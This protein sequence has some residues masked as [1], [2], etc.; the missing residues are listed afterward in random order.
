MPFFRTAADIVRH[1]ESLGLFHVDMGLA[2]MRR[3][4]AALTLSHFPGVVVQ[5]LGTNGKGSTAAFL[6]SLALAHGCRTG[7]YTSPHFVSPAERVRLGLP[8]CGVFAPWPIHRW[9][10]AA[11]DVMDVAPDLTYFEFLTVLA[12]LV[13][14]REGVELVVMEAGLGGRHD[15][16]TAV[17]ADC[18][19]FSPIAMDHRDVLGPTLQDIA[20]DKA[21]A[22]R[23]S[24]PVCMAPQFPLAAAAL[25]EAVRKWKAELVTATPVAADV[26]LGLFGPHQRI[27]AGLALAA[28]DRLA[29]LLGKNRGDSSAESRGLARAFLPGRLQRVPGSSQ[30]PPMLLDGAHNPHGMSAL[31][32]A[33]QAADIHPAG[34]VYA[35]LRD[36][37]WQPA[38]RLLRRHV[39]QVPFFVV[40]LHNPRAARP[41]DIAAVL[42]SPPLA[43]TVEMLHGDGCLSPALVRA[44]A[45]PRAGE[46]NPLL[47]TG[48][49]YLLSEFFALYPRHLSPEGQAQGEVT[50]FPGGKE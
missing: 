43:T 34:V 44:R 12:L 46:E 28:W 21:G 4:L 7:L 15:A 36:K 30:Y 41:E 5:V 2:R 16:T 26:P 42:D 32:A 45:L 38:L 37:D 25:T 14:R 29:P 31:V 8:S 47:M 23:A 24:V 49:L 11:N 35:C 50:D 10:K 3:A 13:F 9:L 6:A 33:L 40:P 48:S 1:L 20:R 19:C 39:G 17:Y 18:L 22:I 27:N